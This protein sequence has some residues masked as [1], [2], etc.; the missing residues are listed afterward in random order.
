MYIYSYN[1]IKTIAPQSKFAYNDK[2][3]I[4]IQLKI[5]L[6]TVTFVQELHTVIFSDI[7]TV[8]DIKINDGN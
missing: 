8:T 7:Q 2:V 4:E 1:E 6:C 5:S 3:K